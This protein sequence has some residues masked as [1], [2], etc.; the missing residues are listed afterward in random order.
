MNNLKNEIQ[1]AI[2][3]NLQN[4]LSKLKQEAHEAF[5]DSE[6]ISHR[7]SWSSGIYHAIEEIQSI[8]NTLQIPSIDS[9]ETL[10]SIIDELKYQLKAAI[11]KNGKYSPLQEHFNK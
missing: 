4:C 5:I 2:E 9:D 6:I 7:R 11:S 10:I 8:S 1:K 3:M